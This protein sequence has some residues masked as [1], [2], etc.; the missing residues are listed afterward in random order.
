MDDVIRCC[1]SSSFVPF[2]TYNDIMYI[3]KNKLSF[4][5]GFYYKNYKQT[6]PS[7]TLII[8]FRMFG[9]HKNLNL[10]TERLKKNK[11]SAY[12]LYMKGY[13]DAANHH[14]YF[15]TYLNQNK[16]DSSSYSS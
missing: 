13:H 3:Y 9:R 7:T 14:A 11:A 8:S 4:D 1:I 16:K 15:E 6:L 12:Q 5:G 2:I 10:V